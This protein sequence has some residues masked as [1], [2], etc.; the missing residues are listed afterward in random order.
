MQPDY[1]FA[2]R[3]SEA[4]T[5]VQRR[6]RQGTVYAN[7]SECLLYSPRQPERLIKLTD[8]LATYALLTRQALNKQQVLAHLIISNLGHMR[9]ISAASRG[10]VRLCGRNTLLPL[11]R[12]GGE[13]HLWYFAEKGW[14]QLSDMCM[15]GAHWHTALMA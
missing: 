8:D 10:P 15:C 14:L 11:L 12:R 9:N 1:T 3:I 7:T 2:L 4:V 6:L 5:A 13:W